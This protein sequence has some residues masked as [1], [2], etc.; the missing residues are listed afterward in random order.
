MD[1]ITFGDKLRELRTARQL[2]LRQLADRSH[3]SRSKLSNW[4]HNRLP[5][6]SEGEAA[7]LDSI[8]DGDG[9]LVATLRTPGL[10]GA[11]ERIAYVAK[12]PRAVDTVAVGVLHD[13]LAGMRQ[14]EDRF[15][16][17]R[18]LVMTAEPVRLVEKLA[19]EAVGDIRPAVVDLAGQWAQFAGW[20][21]AAAGKHGQAHEWYLRALEYA[22]EVDATSVLPTGRELIAT[23]LSMRGHL[24]WSQ[25]KPGPTVGLSA[26]AAKNSRS[27]GIRAMAC[28]Q[29]A[30]GHALL[31]E[32]VQADQLLDLAQ[33]AMADAQQHPEK[34]PPWIYF[35]SPGYLQM[36]RGL[37]ASLLG[38][39]EKAIEE[40]TA[41]L[42]AA[43][44]DVAGAEFGAK[45]KLALAS[46]HLAG[47]NCD[48]ARSLLEEARAT[49][50]ATGSADLAGE[51]AALEARLSD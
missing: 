7:K 29:G 37:V 18:L 12:H 41:G 15:G 21:R 10:N 25:R 22:E 36:Q 33:A 6:P 28:Q 39:R 13:T 30:R 49:A 16:A 24:A 44:D 34:E 31:G 5:L 23:S 45:Y 20:L 38:R 32:A 40:L 1:T 3:Y 47:G 14:L 43:G 19:D 17:D 42:K 2:T 9:A 11:G 51:V 50:L 8:L 26:A 4:E 48:M 35:Y 27:P 46:A